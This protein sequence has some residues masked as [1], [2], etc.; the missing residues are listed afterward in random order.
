M[1]LCMA[2]SHLSRKR[3]RSASTAILQ[4]WL[5]A[6]LCG[7]LAV[8]LP[9]RAHG[10]SFLEDTE[11]V[12]IRAGSRL[13][14]IIRSARRQGYELAD[15]TPV[16]MLEW[17][18]SRW[19]DI[20][21]TFLTRID[22]TFGI[23]WGFGT[24]ERGEKYVI[25]PSLELGF[26]KLFELSEQEVISLSAKALIGGGLREKTCVADY[27]AIG[28]TQV[29]NCRLAASL[30]PPGETLDY[31]FDEPAPDRIEVSLRYTWTF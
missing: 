5:A 3:S 21:V 14:D 22:P 19:T 2:P 25:R 12:D 29:V 24:G 30:L 20:G 31:L 11:F 15:G 6:F 23:Y 1:V 10:Q 8:P 9:E 18:G 4:G 28:G 27:G 26:I 7:V 17:Y 16:D 13:T